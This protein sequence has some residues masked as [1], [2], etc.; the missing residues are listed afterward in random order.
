MYLYFP[1]YFN[2]CVCVYVC[3][4]CTQDRIVKQ[5][6]VI[7]EI[8]SIYVCMSAHHI[9]LLTCTRADWNLCNVV[10]TH[11][12]YFLCGNVPDWQKRNQLIFG[13]INCMSIRMRIVESIVFWAGFQINSL[14][15]IQFV[16]VCLVACVLD[17]VPLLFRFEFRL[18]STK[19]IK[20]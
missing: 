15:A 10:L 3:T 2:V 7:H 19:S 11:C 4:V 16:S 6:T 8:F 18:A 13:I 5:G 12:V 20:L 9:S 1:P 14:C 17:C